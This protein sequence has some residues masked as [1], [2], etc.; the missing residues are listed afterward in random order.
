MTADKLIKMCAN[1]VDILIVEFANTNEEYDLWNTEECTKSMQYRYK[2]ID[3]FDM[4]DTDQGKVLQV[5]L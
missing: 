2:Q 1:P 4:Y 5:W 3:V